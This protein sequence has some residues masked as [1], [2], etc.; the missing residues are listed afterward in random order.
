MKNYLPFHKK[1]LL[2]KF[3]VG[4]GFL[5]SI[6]TFFGKKLFVFFL[7]FSICNNACYSTFNASYSICVFYFVKKYKIWKNSVNDRCARN[8]NRIENF[9]MNFYYFFI[10]NF[11]CKFKLIS[12]FVKIFI[13][14]K[15]KYT[16][17]YYFKYFIN[18]KLLWYYSIIP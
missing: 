3:C 18:Y 8:H 10:M 12:A 1:K 17:L 13:G 4:N 2:N 14:S 16:H 6:R 5:M 11:C 9:A 7:L 15:F